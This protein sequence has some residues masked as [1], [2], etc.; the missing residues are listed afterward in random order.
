MFSGIRY[1]VRIAIF[2]YGGHANGFSLL[3][4]SE[5]GKNTATNKEGLVPFL[6]KQPGLKLIFLN[7]CSSE[8]QANDL[9]KSGIPAVIGTY[10]FH[11]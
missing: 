7:G 11:Q 9:I 3:L 10:V 1:M 8:A 6:S 2:H 4:E 5:D